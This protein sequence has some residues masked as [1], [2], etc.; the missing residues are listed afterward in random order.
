MRERDDAVPALTFIAPMDRAHRTRILTS[1]AAS[2]VALL[3]FAPQAG[4]QQQNPLCNV[5]LVRICPAPPP[6]TPPPPGIDPRGVDPASPNPLAGLSF[7]VD[8]SGEAP[9]YE[10]YSGYQRRGHTR[11]AAMVAKL[12]LQPQFKWFGRWNENDRGGTAGAIRSYLERVGRE[13]PGAVAQIVT[14]RHQGKK[15]GGGYGG[16]GAAEDER[17]RRWYR[18]LARGIGHSRVVI[19]YEPDSLGTIDCLA[20]GRR[21]AR[22]DL[23]RYGIEVLSRLPRATIYIEGGASD[24]EPA[25]R[26]ARQLR[27]VGI[28]KVRGFMLNVTHYDWT[29]HNIRHGAA[30]S[31]RVGGK[32]FIVSTSFNGRGPV[33]YRRWIDRRKKRWRTVNVWCHPLRRG[34]GPAPTTAT[35]HPRAD[36]YLYIGRPGYSGGSCNGGPLPVGS[37]FESR[38][39]MF[40]RYATNWIRPPRGTRH[41]LPGRISTRAL[42]GDQYRR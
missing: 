39:L 4:A 27:H 40:G 37:W 31:R 5:P 23:L 16:G 24:W 22:L 36:A 6:P 13:Q 25:A 15:C 42:A 19:G 12:A 1:F 38:A 30:I 26:T 8:K 20:R 10:Q 32:P 14:L 35:H 33:H 17:T 9:Q 18:D 28:D 2:A 3:T 21:R 29:Q 11:Q 7:F 34:L 41:G